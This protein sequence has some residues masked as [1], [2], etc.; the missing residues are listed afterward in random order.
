MPP[1]YKGGNKRPRNPRTDRQTRNGGLSTFRKLLKATGNEFAVRPA[2]GFLSQ[3][4]GIDE[5]GNVG[6]GLDNAVKDPKDRKNLG[7]VDEV[8]SLPTLVELLGFDPPE[9]AEDA[10]ERLEVLKNAIRDDMGI[11]PPRGFLENAGEALG[12]MGA[13]LPVPGKKKVDIAVEGGKGA[14]SAAKRVLKKVLGSAPEFFS[15]TIQ[16]KVSNYLSGAGFGGLL[17]SLADGSEDVETEDTSSDIGP[18]EF[19]AGGLVAAVAGLNA[20][21]L[22][23]EAAAAGKKP[24]TDEEVYAAIRGNNPLDLQLKRLKENNQTLNEQIGKGEDVLT[25]PNAF[26]VE[27]G[28][29]NPNLRPQGPTTNIDPSSFNRR[30]T[31]IDRSLQDLLNYGMRGEYRYFENQPTDPDAPPPPLL[32]VA[33]P[34]DNALIALQGFKPLS[35]GFLS[36][37][38]NKALEKLKAQLAKPQGM[39]EGGAVQGE[40]SDDQ[41]EQMATML[42]NLVAKYR[43]T[44]GQPMQ[45]ATGGKVGALL[46]AVKPRPKAPAVNLDDIAR[47]LLDSGGTADDIAGLGLSPKAQARLRSLMGELEG[48]KPARSA[49]KVLTPEEKKMRKAIQEIKMSFFGESDEPDLEYVRSVVDQLGTPELASQYK[50]VSDFYNNPGD[51]AD[52]ATS[53]PSDE[54]SNSIIQFEAILDRLTPGKRIPNPNEE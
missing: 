39:A 36:G 16:P 27:L 41:V 31:S 48:V 11:E 43:D 53:G 45:M 37:S 13:Q 26:P 22:R 9:F 19:G 15:P 40:M 3:I 42:T 4:M 24:P 46:K 8:L 33:T 52:P 28:G 14:L 20:R 51:F 30:R 5:K 10:A 12:T 18:Q 6:F 54:L 34:A 38:F 23:N 35:G 32:N 50:K 7:M 17:G 49:R 21:R 1:Q 47:S 29:S 25:N 2:A 44:Q